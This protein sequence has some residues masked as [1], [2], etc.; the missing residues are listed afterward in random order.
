MA[1]TRR[2]SRSSLA[3]NLFAQPQAYEFFQLVRLRELI[4]AMENKAAGR[5]APS[6]VGSGTDPRNAALV[7]RS[8]V[9]LGFAAAEVTSLRQPR[10]G[11]AVEAT[12]TLVGLTG[13]SGVLPHALSE[14]V[15]VS[16][17]ERNPALRDFLDVFNNRLAGLLYEAWAKYRPV[18]A[19]ERAMMLETAN[20]IDAAF[21]ALVG[22]GLPATS[23]RMQTPDD[24]LVYFGGLL[25]RQSRSAVAVESILSGALGHKV[26]IRQFLGVWLPIAEADRTRLPRGR[27]SVGHFAMLG[28]DAV[29]GNRTFDAQSSVL[30]CVGPIHYAA[31]RSL[32]PDGARAGMLTDLTA[33]ALGPDKTCRVR[34]ELPPEEV[35]RLSLGG[36]RDDASAS[37]L[38]WN[39]WLVTDKPRAGAVATEFLPPSHLR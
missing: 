7:I 23:G 18:V 16:V 29:L 31:F 1:S 17:R 2:R 35:P 9:P 34:L 13:P 14:L 15:Q 5:P 37:R 28:R 22:I 26:T 19:R 39:T 36:D 8:S 10:Q 20:T 3:A 33:M 21:K 12:Q 30:V 24:T 32:L 4:A 25:S 27:S 11:G 6:P 38:G